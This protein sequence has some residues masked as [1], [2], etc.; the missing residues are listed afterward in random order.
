MENEIQ[1]LFDYR[2]QQ[3]LNNSEQVESRYSIVGS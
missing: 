2:P 1:S 3:D